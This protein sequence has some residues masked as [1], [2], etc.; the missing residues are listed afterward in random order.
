M[1]KHLLDVVY[2]VVDITPPRVPSNNRPKD[3]HAAHIE[4]AMSRARGD[5]LTWTSVSSPSSHDVEHLQS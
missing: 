3:A 1:H 4:A 5:S 2:D